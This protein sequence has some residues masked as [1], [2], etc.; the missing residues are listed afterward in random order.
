MR[1]GQELSRRQLLGLALGAMPLAGSG[2]CRAGQTK[3]ETQMLK[4]GERKPDARA[5]AEGRL[6]ARPRPAKSTAPTESSAG[7]HELGLDGQRDGLLYVPKG[8]GPERPA[9]LALMLH[10]AGGHAQHGLSLLRH[11]ADDYNLIVLAP[12]SRRA[13]W[14]VI[15]RGGYGPDV[16]FIDRALEQTF[17]RYN[18]DAKR[19]AIGGFSDGASYALSLGLINGELFTHVLAFSPGFA[20]PTGQRGRPRFYVSHGKRDAVLPVDVCSRRLVPQLKR[21]GYDVRYHE[22]DGPHTVPPEI[23]LEAVKWFTAR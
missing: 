17:S 23:A 1:D 10:G 4:A 22:F 18:V 8:H 12:Q 2:L 16:A 14:D 13:T 7:A 20:S 15:A 5:Y 11:L 3:D 19:L 9:P 21:A 6:L